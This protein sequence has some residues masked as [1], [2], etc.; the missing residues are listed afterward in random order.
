MNDAMYS[1]SMNFIERHFFIISPDKI[2]YESF[3]GK[4]EASKINTLDSILRYLQYLK[5]TE[6]VFGY[7]IDAWNKIEHEQPKWKTET[8]FISEQLDRL[9]DFNDY[10]DMHGIV[11]VHPRKIEMSGEN[12]KMPSLYDIKGSSAWKE[13]ADIGILIHRYKMKKLTKDFNPEGLILSDLDDDQ[14]YMVMPDAPTIIRTE[15]I[16]FEE[17]GNEDRVRMRMSS[18]G[19]F[20]VDDPKK[21]E[22][23][24][25]PDNRIEPENKIF[26][27]DDG[28]DELPF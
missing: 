21:F 18:Y 19:Q 22:K 11:I 23:K 3:G 8:S 12:Y 9:I 28:E 13:K 15:K 4:I 25:H 17:T 20:Y 1:K 26:D 16:R 5:K 10:W 6:N 7:V 24:N 2:N 27:D 14:R